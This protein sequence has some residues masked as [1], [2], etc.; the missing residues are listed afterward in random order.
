MLERETLSSL[1]RQIQV[2]SMTFM[3]EATKM[4]G[5]LYILNT[6]TCK[7]HFKVA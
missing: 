5:K 6:F 2:S 3:T 7:T 4:L 1:T